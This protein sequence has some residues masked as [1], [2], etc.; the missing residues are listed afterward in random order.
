MVSHRES[1]ALLWMMDSQQFI[2]S[3]S[4]A[5][6]SPSCC[7]TARVGMKTASQFKPCSKTS[8]QLCS[9]KACHST[10]KGCSEKSGKEAE[11]LASAGFSMRRPRVSATEAVRSSAS[12]WLFIGSEDK[13]IG[14]LKM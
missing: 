4:Q 13:H 11:A 2:H 8:A 12:L 9:R 5:F 10:M 1:H 14:D 6:Q 7:L 3:G